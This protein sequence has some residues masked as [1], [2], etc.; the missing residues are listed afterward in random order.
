[1]R[2]VAC[3][4]QRLYMYAARNYLRKLLT[5]EERMPRSEPCVVRWPTA[6]GY[7]GKL[8]RQLQV[9]EKNIERIPMFSTYIY[10]YNVDRKSPGTCKRSSPQQQAAAT[11]Q[12]K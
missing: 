4:V 7:L 1:M 3:K 6:A 8:M 9:E 12:R 10:T 5:K 2:C 11:L